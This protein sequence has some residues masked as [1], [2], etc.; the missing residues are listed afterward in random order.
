[1]TRN[2]PGLVA[3]STGAGSVTQ[4][5]GSLDDAISIT[6]Y[7]QST[8]GFSTSPA[9]QISQ[10]DPNLPTPQP[11]VVESTNWNNLSSLIA[12]ITS[13]GNAVVICPV[14][15]RGIRLANT[16]SSATSEVVA[17]VSKQILV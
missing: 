5:I 3:Q 10:F 8:A 6:I 14:S 4:G 16:S 7:L 17:Y 11:G 1:M 2:L 13:S 12:A 9:I 15:F